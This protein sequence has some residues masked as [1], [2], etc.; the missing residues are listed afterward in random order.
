MRSRL[1]ISISAV[2]KELKIIS[3]QT[4]ACSYQRCLACV[5]AARL[6]RDE[7]K[8]KLAQL[9]STA[10]DGASQLQQEMEMEKK[11]RTDMQVASRTTA[12]N[13]NGITSCTATPLHYNLHLKC[14]KIT[15]VRL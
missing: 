2:R 7:A 10:L 13:S 6:E 4:H 11:Q 8:E 1:G 5:Q 14:W 3:L 9:E 12:V 15:S